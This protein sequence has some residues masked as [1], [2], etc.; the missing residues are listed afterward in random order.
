VELVGRAR[1]EP[2]DEVQVEVACIVGLGVDEQASAADVLIGVEEPGDDIAEQASL[3]SSALVVDVDA[4][5][6]EQRDQWG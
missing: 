2:G 1:S 4:E 6:G 3:K 5:A